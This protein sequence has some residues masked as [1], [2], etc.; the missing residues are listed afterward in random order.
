MTCCIASLVRP[1]AATCSDGYNSSSYVHTRCR[2]RVFPLLVPF[3]QQPSGLTGQRAKPS[4]TI[5]LECM[6][7]SEITRTTLVLE[8]IIPTANLNMFKEAKKKTK[9]FFGWVN[10]LEPPRNLKFYYCIFAC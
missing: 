3:L 9:F 5:P 1:R 4:R 6:P 8:M 10:L 7:F 2:S